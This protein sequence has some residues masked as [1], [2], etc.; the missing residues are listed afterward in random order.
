MY[1]MKPMAQSLASQGRYGDTMLVHMNPVEVAGLDAYTRKMGGGGLTVNPRTGQPEA[2]L[3]FLLGLGLQGLGMTALQAGLATGIGT[4]VATKDLGKGVL[5]GLGAFGGA[6]VGAGLGA[7]G[8]TSATSAVPATAGADI[9]AGAS[10]ATPVA[11]LPGAAPASGSLLQSAGT[12]SFAPPTGPASFA[13]TASAPLMPTY[14]PGAPIEPSSIA[15]GFTQ[16]IA[17]PPPLSSAVTEGAAK[18]MQ[19]S[20]TAPTG[21]FSEMGQG[22][23]ALGTEPGRAAFMKSVGGGG[24][25]ATDIGFGALSSD[26]FMDSKG[27]RGASSSLIRPYD[28]DPATRRFTARNPYRAP[29]PEYK[30]QAGGLASQVRTGYRDG[31]MVRGQ[32]DGMSD[33]ITATIEGEQDVLLSDGEYVI[34][35]DVVAML[36]NG[37]SESG[38][39]VITNMI[40]RLRMKK[41]GRDKQ[42]PELDEE[43]MLPA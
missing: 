21:G 9:V 3:P 27:A 13:P 23:Q 38:E 39:E 32:G 8:A 4:A 40:K 20:L 42:P 17:P 14:G 16:P 26:A 25:L 41:Y 31:N 37:S 6:D 24:G 19:D 5:A 10:Q 2:F 29:G 28:F 15:T 22:F 11:G 12:S 34:P 18:A 7:A 36:G 43:E 33:E 35:A 1:D 30:F